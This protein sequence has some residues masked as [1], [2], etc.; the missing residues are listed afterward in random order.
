MPPTAV[1]PYPA[2]MPFILTRSAAR[3]ID[4]E[5]QSRHG[6]SG[7]ELMERAARGAVEVARTMAQPGDRV[8]VACGRGSNGGDGWAM[9]RLLHHLGYIVDIV[10]I[11]PPPPGSDAAANAE[12]AH[13]LAL[14]HRPFEHGLPDADLIIDAVFGTGLNRMLTGMALHLIGAINAHPAPVL[15]IDLPSGLDVDSGHA[16]GDAVQAAATATCIGPKAGFAAPAA[17]KSIGA[18]HIIDLGVPDE[19]IRRHAVEID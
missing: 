13:A 19:L 1:V 16:L 7:L 15:A 11:G 18:V 5:A 6:L 9:A 10:S 14:N 12:L 3:C 2:F 8:L 4:A 17:Q